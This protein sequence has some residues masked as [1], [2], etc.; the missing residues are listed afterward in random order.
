MMNDFG[1][2][3]VEYPVSPFVSESLVGKESWSFNLP[4]GDIH[5][6]DSGQMMH[7]IESKSVDCVITDPA[8][9]TLEKWRNVGT[10]TR[11]GGGLKAE[12]RDESKW[13]KVIQPDEL[14]EL[15]DECS[16]VLTKDSHCW[17]MCDGSTLG[18]ILAHGVAGYKVSHEFNYIKPYPVLKKAKTGGYRAGL[19]YHGR[20]AHEFVVLL[21]KGR[22]KFTDE[23]W[24]DVFECEWN[25]DSETRPFTS[26]GKPY[27]TAKPL[28]FFKRLIELSTNE[29]ETVLDPFMGSGTTVVAASQTGRRFIGMDISPDAVLTTCRRLDV[30][31][32]LCGIPCL[33][34]NS[35]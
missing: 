15:I 13:F 16:R 27:P 3:A 19:G 21:E 23:N 32:C 30:L 34:E 24:P 5:F 20:G 33:F 31:K 17:M 8:Y 12:N 4:D 35:L 29:G 7:S 14:V 22:R 11:L 10:T 2:S 28:A 1:F 18:Y 25:G 9:W 26:N 6:D